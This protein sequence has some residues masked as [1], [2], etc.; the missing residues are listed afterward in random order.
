ME[1]TGPRAIASRLISEMLHRD[2]GAPLSWGSSQANAL[3]AIATLGG[4]TGLGARDV[5]ALPTLQAH[6]RRT[7]CAICWR[8]GAGYPAWRRSHRY[9]GPSPHPGR[10]W[11]EW[12]PYLSIRWSISAS[13]YL[14]FP[15]HFL[16][17][18]DDERALFW[19][20]LSAP[21]HP[22]SAGRWC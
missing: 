20:S 14:Q 12:R 19:Q 13:D 3:M 18:L 9:R 17:Q 21:R 11:H 1:A 15:L 16:R 6:P 5:P 7:A 2:R 4:K 22:T 10:S 8:S